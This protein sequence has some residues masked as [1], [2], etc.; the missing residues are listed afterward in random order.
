MGLSACNAIVVFL[1]IQY[2]GSFEIKH[3]EHFL[4]GTDTIQTPEWKVTWWRGE[5]A[6][7]LGE[8]KLNKSCEGDICQRYR[9]ECDNPLRPTH[10]KYW[11][12]RQGDDTAFVEVV[13][14]NADGFKMATA[15]VSI[16]AGPRRDTPIRLI[17]FDREGPSDD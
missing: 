9:R 11:L 12:Q 13:G 5:R 7:S 17:D 10:C 6:S 4:Y 14:T 15:F 8:A 1:C 16:L 3:D 2:P